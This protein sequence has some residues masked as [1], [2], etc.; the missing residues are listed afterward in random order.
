MVKDTKLYDILG[1]KPEANDKELKKAYFDLSK[2]WH[3]DRNPPEKKEECTKKFQ[4]ISEAYEVLSTPDKRQHY[5][6]F[7]ETDNN[8]LPENF[9]P[10]DIF[11]AAFGGMFNGGSPFGGGPFRKQQEDCVV[12]QNVSLEELFCNKKIN[13][14]YT[15]KVYCN[16]CNGTGSKDGKSTE[17]NGCNG[18]GK[19]VK[20]LKQGPM[21]QQMVMPCDDCGGTGEKIKKDNLCEHCHGN[22]HLLKN[23]EF[24]LLLNKNYMNNTKLVIEQ[25]GHVLK[26]GKTNLIII[27][28]EQ[29]HPVF[30][31][32]GKDLHINIRLRLFQALYGFTKIVTHLDGRNIVLKYD[33]MISQMKTIMKIKNEGFGGHLFVHITTYMPKLD[34][35]DEQENSIL[36]KLLIK[37]HLSEFQKEQNIQ[38]NIEQCH[39]VSLEEIAEEEETEYEHDNNNNNMPNMPGVQ[40]AQQ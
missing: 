40:C 15:Q 31:R 25:M 27:L 29:P 8:G 38:K 30:I 23:K 4:E 39:L 21:I 34:K 13:I 19:K 28:K 9:N 22:K 18:K 6:N 20:L 32:K 24:E 2:K 10:A 5:D 35:L 14:N 26:H 12:E 17:C 7:G 1:V 3:P 16:T 37:A 36:K 11:G 33:K